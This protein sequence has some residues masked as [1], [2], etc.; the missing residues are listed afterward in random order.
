MGMRWTTYVT[1]GEEGD[2]PVHFDNFRERIQGGQWRRETGA[3][4]RTGREDEGDA[5]HTLR[6][7]SKNSRKPRG[8]IG[9][10]MVQLR[11]RDGRDNRTGKR[12]RNRLG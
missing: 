7:R 2:D 9:G 4:R 8:V 3:I 1:G 10:A 6:R 5:R 11:G 12:G